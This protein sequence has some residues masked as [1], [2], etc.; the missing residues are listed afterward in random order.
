MR[1]LLSSAVA[2]AVLAMASGCVVASPDADTYEDAAASSVGSVAGEV[3]T[4]QLLLD[5][6]DRHRITDAAVVTQLR[7]SEKNL[8]AAAQGLTG[9]NPPAEEDPVSSKAGDLFE[10]AE[11]LV[12]SARI[13]VHRENTAQYATIAS[14]LKALGTK[15][16]KLEGEVS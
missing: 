6:L 16:Q 7:Y 12:E 10:Q 8:A 15:L 2:I 13:A 14:S 1:R 5:L 9:L 4:V 11:N 3:A